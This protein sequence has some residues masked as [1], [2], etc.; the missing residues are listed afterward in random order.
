MRY[1][2]AVRSTARFASE[3]VVYRDVLFPQ[4]TLVATSL[5]GANRDPEAFTAPG[6]FDIT[7]ERGTAQMTFGS[8]IHFCMGAALARA[9]LQ[10]ALPLLARRMPGL[11]RNGRDRVEALVVRHLGT[12]APPAALRTL[13]RAGYERSRSARP[14]DNPLG[15]V[16]AEL[17]TQ[18]DGLLRLHVAPGGLAAV[19]EDPGPVE[20]AAG[21]EGPRTGALA[22]C[23]PVGEVPIGEVMF[24]ESSRRHPE[25]EVAGVRERQ[26]RPVEEPREGQQAV[27]DVSQHGFFR[28]DPVGHPT[29]SAHRHGE[30]DITRHIRAAVV[31]QPHVVHSSLVDSVGLGQRAGQRHPPDRRE[32]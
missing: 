28:P 13:L 27:V 6:V 15:T 1:L 2:G 14:R 10:E 19:E 17:D 5:A 32:G 20:V 31:G 25:S 24:A 29:E 16:H 23:D 3:D 26:T 4:G 8:G 11:G 21:E 7:T 18:R 9:E 12:G 30:L 22:E